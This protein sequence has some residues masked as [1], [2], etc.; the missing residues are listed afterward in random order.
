MPRQARQ[1]RSR[2]RARV[3]IKDDDDEEDEYKGGNDD[4]LEDDDGECNKPTNKTFVGPPCPSYNYAVQT[5]YWRGAR[6]RLA[7]ELPDHFG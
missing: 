1:A 4:V 7:H 6:G 5:N 2:T 3:A